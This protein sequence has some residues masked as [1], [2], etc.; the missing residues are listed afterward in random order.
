MLDSGLQLTLTSSGS[1]Y[2]KNENHT[3]IQRLHVLLIGNNYKN[4]LSSSSVKLF[5]SLIP[6]YVSVIPVSF[7]NFKIMPPCS[8]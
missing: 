2:S 3:L 7:N 1:V 5:H 4:V 8:N 6:V